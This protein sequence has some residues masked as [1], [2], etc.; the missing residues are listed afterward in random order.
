M[1]PSI[2]LV[3]LENEFFKGIASYVFNLFKNQLSPEV[4]YHNFEHTQDVVLHANKIG[5][6]E[7]ITEE[8]LE[9]LLIA[10][11]FHDTGFVEDYEKHEE[12][13]KTIAI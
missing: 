13:S 12:K 7:K 4:V 11:W 2:V 9:L 3:M 6:A 1:N 5:L 8:D 10:C